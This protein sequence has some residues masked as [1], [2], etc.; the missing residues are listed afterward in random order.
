V[1]AHG[2]LVTLEEQDRTRWDARAIAEGSALVESA[3]RGKGYGPYALEAAIAGLHAQATTAGAT[4][5]P[6]IAALY[7]VL[8]EVKP[9]PVVM[10]N[11]AVAI[12]MA[13]G[14]E[15]G[16]ALLEKLHLPRYHLLPAAR[17]DLLRRLHRF[18]EAAA[19]YRE[20][21]ALVTHDVER[22]FLERRLREVG[23]AVAPMPRSTR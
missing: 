9:T 19:A 18:D 2:G 13:D 5:W 17:A 16:L 4:D 20:A 11:R 22:R 1:D 8:L 12:A 6:Q 14:V 3:L 7:S 23:E 10:L 15:R 21:L